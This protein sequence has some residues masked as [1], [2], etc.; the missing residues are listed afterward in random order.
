MCKDNAVGNGFIFVD[1]NTRL[2]IHHQVNKF[3]QENGVERM[4]C[5]AESPDGNVFELTWTDPYIY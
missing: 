4:D 5:L 2:H 1:D 3:V